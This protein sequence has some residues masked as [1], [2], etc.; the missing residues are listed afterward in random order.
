MPVRDP[1][2]AAAEGVALALLQLRREEV[3]G[4]AWW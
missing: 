1:H 3:R 2:R 4:G